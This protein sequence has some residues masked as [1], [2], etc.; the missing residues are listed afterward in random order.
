MIRETLQ[1]ALLIAAL[2]FGTAVAPAAS[3]IDEAAAA[4][5]LL[6]GRGGTAVAVDPRLRPRRCAVPLAVDW[7]PGGRALSVRCTPDGWQVFVTVASDGG[8]K[9]QST[10]MAVR[11]RSA[12]MRGSKIT[13]G[14]LE[15]AAVTGTV[16][17]DLLRSIEAASGHRLLRSVAPGTM[18]RLSMLEQV[19][20]VRRRDRVTIKIESPGFAVSAAGE[21][22][23]N[24][25]PGNRVLVRNLSSGKKLRGIV[26]AD[27]NILIGR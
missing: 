18:L 23:E 20:T 10:G 17:N 5:L 2:L 8:G 14:D 21:A 11:L 7:L 25:G 19:P 27:G 16:G 12:L 24:G 26:A 6:D 15:M 4:F 22:L 9:P 13:P 1:T 3:M